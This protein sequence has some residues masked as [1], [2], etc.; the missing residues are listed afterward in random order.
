MHT[1]K[2]YANRKHYDKAQGHYVTL[3]QIAEL[4]RAQEDFQVLDHVTGKDL[5]SQTLAQVI[6]E[7]AKQGSTN[8]PAESLAKII[9]EGLI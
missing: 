9:R 3:A 7:E 2:R 1:I 5:T 4:V 8:L 6:F